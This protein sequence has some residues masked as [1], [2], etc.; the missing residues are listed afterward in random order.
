MILLIRH[1]RAQGVEGRY[2]GRTDPPLSALG[3]EQAEALARDLAASGLRTLATSPLLRARQTVEPLARALDLTPL[4]LDDLA[5]IDLGT[6]DGRDREAVRAE[7]PEA[8]AARGRDFAHFRTP[9]GETF[10]EVLARGLRA[11]DALSRLPGPVAAVTHA[12]VVRCLVRSLRGQS[13]DG[14]FEVRVPETGCTPVLPGPH[15]FTVPSWGVPA[16]A[17]ALPLGSP[18]EAPDIPSGVPSGAGGPGRG[19]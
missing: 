10:A 7:Q 11:L 16:S 18:G 8:H 14:L 15:G 12:G 2:I 9:G 4:V 6:W 17:L 3:R 1:A 19:V 5:E 13:L